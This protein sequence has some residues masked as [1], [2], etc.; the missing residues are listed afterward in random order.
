MVKENTW[1]IPGLAE[2][3]ATIK[4]SL[5]PVVMIIP[6]FRHQVFLV[7]GPC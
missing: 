4:R 3:G 7:L 1:E 6:L 2:T 5:V